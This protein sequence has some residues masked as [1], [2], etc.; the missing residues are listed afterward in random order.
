MANG[1]RAPS[2]LSVVLTPYW[3]PR[4]IMNFIHYPNCGSYS[5]LVAKKYMNFIHYLK[6]TSRWL[7]PAIRQMCV[8]LP[9]SVPP[10]P[11]LS[12]APSPPFYRLYIFFLRVPHIFFTFYTKSMCT[13]KKKTPHSRILFKNSY[14]SGSNPSI[15]FSRY[16]FSIHNYKLY[17]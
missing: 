5:L 16:L 13:P 12:A 7:V 6:N 4:H 3:L 10:L 8:T 9:S 17:I 11:F 14:G 15:E 2:L 1:H